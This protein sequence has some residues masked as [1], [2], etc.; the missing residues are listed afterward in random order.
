MKYIYSMQNLT[1]GA[2]G[3][4]MSACQ[5]KHP[6]EPWLCFMSPHMNDVIETPFFMFNSKYDAWQLGNEFQS[7][8]TTKAEQA[9]VLQY[10]KDFLTG[11]PRDPMRVV[12]PVGFSISFYIKF[13]IK[14][15]TYYMIYVS[16]HFHL[17]RI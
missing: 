7:Q 9:G 2:D 14:H 10:G 6:T 11:F 12:I 8:W 15:A 13:Y 16:L 3:G 5:A 17:I 4:L 1:F